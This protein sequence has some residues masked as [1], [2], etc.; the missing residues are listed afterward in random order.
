MADAAVAPAPA[1]PDD[2]YWGS[3]AP[4][5]GAPQPPPTQYSGGAP[6]GSNFARNA[7]VA[8]SPTGAPDPD[9][10]YWG[11]PAPN[12]PAA[13]QQPQAAAPAAPQEPLWSKALG[14]ITGYYKGGY[15]ETAAVAA[16]AAEH[17]NLAAAPIAMA[18]DWLKAKLEGSQPDTQAQDWWFKHAVAPL[19]ELSQ[20][21]SGGDNQTFGEKAARAVTQVGSVIASAVLTKNTA[22]AATTNPYLQGAINAQIPSLNSAIAVG[23]HAY[24][25]TNDGP[26]AIKLAMTAYVTSV[27]QMAVPLSRAGGLATRVATG[28]PMY[29][30]GAEAQR[31]AS[32]AMLPTPMSDA[33]KRNLSDQDLAAQNAH[34][35]GVENLREPFSVEGVV[36]NLAM[37][38]AMAGFMGPRVSHQVVEIH[39]TIMDKVQ[40]TAYQAGKVAEGG[41]EL[42]GV[43]DAAI[44][45]ATVGAHF[46]AAAYEVHMQKQEADAAAAKAAEIEQAYQDRGLQQQATRD[47]AFPGARNQVGEQQMEQAQG[48]EQ[49][50][51]NAAPPPTLGDVVPPETQA[52]MRTL[53]E[54]RAAAQ[55]TEEPIKPPEEPQAP[56]EAAP[57]EVGAQE[58]TAEAAPAVVPGEAVPG[59]GEPVRGPQTLAQ[60]RQER[61]F[62]L[63]QQNEAAFR[64]TA[65]EG[66]DA[67][68]EDAA[69]AVPL[70]REEATRT[71]QPFIDAHGADHF[72]VGQNINDPEVPQRIRDD[73]ARWNHPNPRAV[74]D[75][76]EDKIHI[77]ADAHTSHEAMIDTA[78]H[79]TAH[80]GVQAYLGKD[81]KPVMSDIAGNASPEGKAWMKDY[82]SQHGLDPKNEAHVRL[83]ADEYGAHLAEHVTE[84][85]SLLRR[86]VDSVRSGLRK[87]GVV[88]EWS[89]NDI[90]ALIR[91]STPSGARASAHYRAAAERKGDGLR[92]ADQE[93]RAPERAEP[94]SPTAQAAK[95][96]RHLAEQEN[97]NPGVVRSRED[98]RRSGIGLSAEE[99]GVEPATL[100]GKVSEKSR[101]GMDHTLAMISLH[102][103][104]D[105]ID[106]AKMP[107]A[108]A[109]SRN[110]SGMEGLKGTMNIEDEKLL[111]R[112]ATYRNKDVN[113]GAT[114]NRLISASTLGGSSPLEHKPAYSD[115]AKAKDPQKA[116]HD[117]MREGLH[118]DLKKIYKS[119]LLDD[120]GRNLYK[121]LRDHYIARDDAFHKELE[122][123]IKSEA[124]SPQAE[125]NLLDFVRQQRESGR[126]LGDYFPLG[127]FGDRWASAK[128][129]DGTPFGFMRADTREQ[130]KAWLDQR[131]AEGFTEDQLQNGQN[132]NSVG[133]RGRIDPEFT[134][135]IMKL[136]GDA[137]P[138][139][140]GNDLIDEIW[141]QHLKNMPDM[142]LRK[143]FIHRQGRLGFTDD[144]IRTF[145]SQA[146]H[147]AHQIARLR[148]VPKLEQNLDNMQAQAKAL[149]NSTV[150]READWANAIANEFGKRLDW[151][152]NPQNAAWSANLNKLGFLWYLGFA[153][154]T[155][156]RIS[157]QN[158]MIAQPTLAAYHEKASGGIVKANARATAALSGAVWDWMRTEGASPKG[159]PGEALRNFLTGGE[160]QAFEDGIKNGTFSNT[161]TN[162]LASGASGKPM[163]TQMDRIIK[164]SGWLFNAME[165]KNRMS[166]YLAAYRMGIQDGMSQE[167]A[168]WHAND[169][170]RLSHLDYSNVNRPRVMQGDVAKAALLFKSYSAGVTYRLARE[171]KNGFLAREDLSDADKRQ[172]KIAFAGLMGRQML[173][174]GAKGA[175]MAPF[176]FA[177]INYA[178]NKAN[179]D[180]HMDSEAAT[181]EWLGRELG[182]TAADAIM[183]G[184]VS[185]ATGM[186]FTG[187]ASYGDLWYR[188]PSK[189]MKPEDQ[190]ND[191]LMQMAGATIGGIPANM[192]EGVNM[193]GTNNERALEHFLPPMAAS[194]LKAGRYA[195]E[196][197]TDVRGRQLLSKEQMGNERNAPILGELG[198]YRDVASQALGIPPM[199][200]T[201]V[202]NWRNARQNAQAALDARH[203]ELYDNFY[204]AIRGRSGPNGEEKA[205]KDILAFAQA[206]PQ[207][208]RNLRQSLRES[209][210]TKAKNEAT[211]VAGMKT[212]RKYS[213]LDQMYGA[214]PND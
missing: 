28:A 11:S 160:K 2:A 144:H 164:A 193:L 51:A 114:L 37:G 78:V 70:T 18:A 141:Q 15:Q 26:L 43:R 108:R 101:A 45:N 7:Q 163:Y 76:K 23:Q 196:G 176:I 132:A 158:E 16:G 140:K 67:T 49:G 98:L 81:Y 57:R 12:K 91:K 123:R 61:E 133:D 194:L 10:A 83:A 148:Y 198:K 87:M 42:A 40:Q 117:A 151:V 106:P 113:K 66:S 19:D 32:N 13:P 8:N 115:E 90:R 119:R 41:D 100:K 177:A 59:V 36:Q 190:Y 52:A 127:R 137:V 31:E 212:G 48:V 168:T 34:E 147:S 191:F 139:E 184:P 6:E 80:R 88:H 149:R 174:S 171:F 56:I 22:E 97:Y 142:S 130:V 199:S 89:D 17:V 92:F 207:Y 179:P 214:N 195:T 150:P 169:M 60:R 204:D 33:E 138:G 143:N 96:A 99:Q 136:V 105:N 183:Y 211:N 155:A 145:A 71:L 129:K 4:G 110:V 157:T 201:N 24:Q 107:D 210:R 134:R 69:R 156:L 1:D 188:P 38:G 154:G 93:D 86:L 152:K 3:S 73:A 205:I 206:N 197:V 200:A 112:L 122:A 64:D 94:D 116:Q 79:E 46:D 170:A 47:Q 121:E 162:M 77:F 25:E 53:A 213:S 124:A 35:A 189:E 109:F 125:K 27:A 95:Y 21:F 75:P 9:D 209:V 68:T 102:N 84:D 185:A 58:P 85:P 173:F 50:N 187:G 72:R 181:H 131:K 167:E 175:I 182:H 120:E 186:S 111:Q 39:N 208:S 172:A 126:V 161:A 180:Q 166:T 14:Q 82:M 65:P 165:H 44:A 62:K 55:P 146:F 128:F 74:Y 178:F 159:T 103:L 203:Q 54:R 153:P 118:Q 5:P 30:A 20:S 29:A 202:Y 192:L 135:K 63:R 104:P